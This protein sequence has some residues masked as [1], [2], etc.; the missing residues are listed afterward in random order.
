MTKLNK[1][2]LFILKFFIKN[3][4]IP[5]SCEIKSIIA[6]S[7]EIHHLIVRGM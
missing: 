5:K 2:N 6:K 7:M 3:K 1:L 4:L